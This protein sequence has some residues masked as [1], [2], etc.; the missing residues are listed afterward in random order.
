MYAA[1]LAFPKNLSTKKIAK[2]LSYTI[3]FTSLVVITMYFMGMIV[4]DTNLRGSITRLS[5]GFTSPNAF[6]N[7]VLLWMLFYVYYKFDNWDYKSSALCIFITCVVYCITNSRMAFAMEMLLLVVIHFW[8]IRKRNEHKLLYTLATCAYPFF[9]AVCYIVTFIYSKGIFY[10]QLSRLN[11]FMSYRLGFMKNYLNE[12]GVKPFGQVIQTVS[13]AQQLATGETWSGLDNSYMYILIC[14]GL[15]LTILLCF[16]Y[17]MLG[18]YLKKHG[19]CIGAICV[20]I[21]CIVGLTESYLTN[22][23]YNLAAI[24]IAEMLSS[25]MIRRE[26]SVDEGFKAYEYNTTRYTSL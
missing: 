19:N 20:L 7:T 25:N 6:G 26:E 12:Y 13:R 24:L 1:I 2:W 5:Y 15:V 14:W 3:F 23:S 17:I 11:K 16:L 4:G 18:K 22:I 9:T 21:F 10:S 8:L